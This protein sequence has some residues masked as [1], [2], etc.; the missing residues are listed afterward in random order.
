MLSGQAGPSIYVPAGNLNAST[1]AFGRQRVSTP[2]TIFDS[3]NLLD[4]ND[5]FDESTSGSG[6]SSHTVNTSSVDMAVT[7]A[8]G[9]EVIRQ[10]YRRMSYQP[11]KSM[12]NMNTFV[13]NEAK[14]GLRQRVGLFDSQNG[15]FLQQDDSAIS[16]NLRSFVGGSAS[17]TTILQ[18]SWNVD[19]LDGTGPSEQALDLTKSQIMWTDLEWLGVG[20]VRVGFIIN[21]QFV[22]CH[23]FHNANENANVYMTTPN[24]PIRYEITNTAATSGASTLK[25]ICST[26]MSEGGY[27]ARAVRQMIGT[28]S[29]VSGQTV[30]TAY[31]NLVTIKLRKS[32]PIVLPAS[33]DILNISN[34]DFEYALF[35]NATPATAFS[36]SNATDNV[37][38]SLEAKTFSATGTRIGGGYLGGKTAP[39]NIGQ[40]GGFNWEYQ[41]GEDLSGVS[42]T[43]TLAIKAGGP[44]KNAAGILKWLE[45]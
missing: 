8:S 39:V 41:L 43:V 18:S 35:K 23:V 2:F 19:P 12:L 33:A 10:S 4:E 7:D 30:G 27:D 6:S 5:L 42:D 25:Q 45:L 31:V 36:F 34:E 26:V 32:G 28:A 29:M 20:S 38:Y 40:D 24:L 16:F 3:H 37:S 11:G 15:I 9:D 17:D 21:G 1:D 44:S 13:F 22:L 14:T